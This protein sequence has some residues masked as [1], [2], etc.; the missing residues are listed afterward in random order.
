M[1][2]HFLLGLVIIGAIGVGLEALDAWYAGRKER[3]ASQTKRTH[4]HKPSQYIMTH[5]DWRE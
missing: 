4:W 2:A 1:I 5:Q 3:A